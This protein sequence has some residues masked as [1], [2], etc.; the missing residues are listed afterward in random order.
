[1]RR[2]PLLVLIAVPMTLFSAG[3]GSADI[4]PLQLKASERARVERLACQD[5]HGLTMQALD[6]HTYGRG[7]S[8]PAIAE[9]HCAA[10]DMFEGN[11]V[12]YLVQ[13]AR[14]QGEW[15]CHGQWNE[16]LVGVGAE[17]IPVRVEGKTP[18][19]L[20]YQVVQKVAGGGLFQGY[21]LR[22]ALVP[23][24]YVNRGAAQEFID[25]KCEGWHI[26]V[27]TWCPQSECPRVLSMTKT[28]D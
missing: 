1:M 5:P 12:H 3:A 18:L 10:H 7:A 27:S 25:V 15:S 13:C 9:V 20:S 28:G 19:A 24:C 11:P 8:V 2:H 21:P 23:P 4:H 26:I 22:K 16:I 14:E 6:G 17:R